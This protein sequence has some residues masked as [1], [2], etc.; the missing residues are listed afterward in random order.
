[1]LS[2]RQRKAWERRVRAFTSIKPSIKASTLKLAKIAPDSEAPVRLR[3]SFSYL[4]QPIQDRRVSDRT[5]PSRDLRPPATR[6]M[7]SKGTALRFE[8]TAIAIAQQPGTRLTKYSIK[9]ARSGDTGWADLVASPVRDSIRGGRIHRTALDKRREQVKSALQS[10]ERAG[11]VRLGGGIK[12]YEN[13]ELLDEGGVAERQGDLLLPYKLPKRELSVFDLPAGF[14]ENGWIHVLQDSEIAL[15]LM[16]CCGA[17]AFVD[18]V[19][20]IAIPSETRVRHYGLGRDS[21]SAALFPLESLGLLKVNSQGRHDDGQVVAYEPDGDLP[22]LHRLEL[23][24]EG[25]EKSAEDVGTK[26]FGEPE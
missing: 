1:M 12:R 3:R 5:T 24:A 14:I 19:D 11:L 7:S 16:L 26:V 13:F 2:A 20:G 22:K 15:I 23:L 4:S 10:L 8:L 21:F 25:F 18:Q 17:G 6:L 9:P